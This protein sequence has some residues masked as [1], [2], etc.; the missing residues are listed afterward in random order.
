MPSLLFE[1]IE[2]DF[3]FG[4]NIDTLITKSNY[5]DDL[6]VIR[7]FMHTLLGTIDHLNSHGIIYRDIRPSNIMINNEGQIKLLDFDSATFFS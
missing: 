4:T 5:F 2:T 1:K 6:D 3:R 7:N